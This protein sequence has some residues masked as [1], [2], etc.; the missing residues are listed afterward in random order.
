MGKSE[1]KIDRDMV[2]T[3]SYNVLKCPKFWRKC[4]TC[5]L[6]CSNFMHTDSYSRY[7]NSPSAI[8]IY[9]SHMP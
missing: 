8:F 3:M 9:K 7:S 5:V 1:L 2:S 6:Q 4:P